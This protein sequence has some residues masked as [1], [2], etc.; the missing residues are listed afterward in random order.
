MV[1]RIDAPYLAESKKIVWEVAPYLRGRGLDLGAG[2]FKIL[3]HAIS[4]DNMNHAQFGFTVRPDVMCDVSKMDVFGSQS[5]DWV[6]SSHTLEHVEDMEIALKEWWR[7]VKPNGFLILYLPHKDFYPH[8][9][10]PGANPDHKR[11]I[12]PED[13]IA[14]MPAGW[15]LVE[16][17]DR[18]EDEVYSFLQI[19]KKIGGTQRKRS[20][21]NQRPE[22]TALVVRY[23]AFGDVLQASSVFKGL[24][25]Q[26]FH[27]TVH[28]SPPGSDVIAYDPNIDSTILFD[29][30]QVPN[31]NLADFWKWQK[32]KYD[33]FVNLSESVE[34]TFLAMH[35][36][37]QAQWPPTVRHHMMNKNYLEFQHAL[38]RVPH[39]PQ[40]KF[41]ST[42]EERQW[43]KKTRAKMGVG[44][45]IMWSLA[46][47]S[48]HKTWAG[49][50]NILANIMLSYPTAEVVLVGGAEG[51]IL[52]RGWENEPRIK[53]T[54]GK[55][56][57]RNTMSFL[58]ECD[59]VIGPET[60][61]M[62][63]ASCMDVPKVVLLSHST[64]ENLTRD[65]VNTVGIFSGITVC[66]GRGQN[67]A[68]ACH[69]MHYSWDTCT[70]H[71]E[72]G[73]A[74]CQA[75]IDPAEVWHAVANVLE[76]YVRKA[77]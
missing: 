13:V 52:E 14:A 7:L 37:A 49:M 77:A 68:P 76:E 20:Y 58:S 31:G 57:I 72:S 10:Q 35:D 24:K 74:Q 45:I 2:D 28:C 32:K 67:E 9:G 65:W 16:N 6:Y 64:I 1:W 51:V 22:K 29:K 63:A 21:L 66:R 17:Q 18:N 38:A 44:P 3:P 30:D 12:G 39:K 26:G 4:V 70:K 71:E 43:A 48:V 56:N 42:A 73:T 54:S 47:S 69:M 8:M 36:R 41:F 27:V 23:G 75:D 25:D 46:G 33:R 11:D 19:Y 62:N 5:M 15:D 40:V 60:G 53:K 55:W 61:V 34:G 59:L 50:D